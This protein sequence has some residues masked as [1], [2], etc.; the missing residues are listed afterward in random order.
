MPQLLIERL[1]F[2]VFL[3]IVFPFILKSK[4]AI[5][6]DDEEVDLICQV[7][8]VCQEHRFGNDNVPLERIVVLG[9]SAY[10]ERQKMLREINVRSQA[11]IP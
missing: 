5:E 6:I 4:E 7:F 1:S 3:F 2:S 8:V 10:G 11:L 9:T